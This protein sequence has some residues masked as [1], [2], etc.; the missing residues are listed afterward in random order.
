[1]ITALGSDARDSSEHLR[2]IEFSDGLELHVAGRRYV[3]D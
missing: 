1:M 2:L 3:D